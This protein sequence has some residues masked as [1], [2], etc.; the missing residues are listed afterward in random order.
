MFKI[1][2]L[3][4]YSSRNTPQTLTEKGQDGATRT[5]I[6]LKCASQLKL[7]V[8]KVTGNA[9]PEVLGYVNASH[10]ACTRTYVLVATLASKLTKNG[11]NLLPTD[12]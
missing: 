8:L 7:A 12:M 2:L 11:L 10:F 6:S 3:W 9:R 4:Q 1:W 5:G